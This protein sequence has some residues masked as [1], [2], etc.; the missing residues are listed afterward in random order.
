ME[1][2]FINFSKFFKS[3]GWVHLCWMSLLNRN[4]GDAIAVQDLRGIHVWNFV[5]CSP[6]N[7]NPGAAP[8]YSIYSYT[9]YLSVVTS[10]PH[11]YTWRTPWSLVNLTLF[12]NCP[13]CKFYIVISVC[14]LTVHYNST[15]FPLITQ[16]KHYFIWKGF[17]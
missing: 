2:F 8:I 13:M 7:Q 3:L 5:R 6:S 15:D 1:I 16:L 14:T 10:P 4:F 12:N 11:F 17:L 9:V